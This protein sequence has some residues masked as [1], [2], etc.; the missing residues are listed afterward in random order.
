[1]EQNNIARNL[2]A[3][4][5]LNHLEIC[6][7]NAIIYLVGLAVVIVTVLSLFGLA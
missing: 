5:A 2:G 4:G 1:V 3:R 7:M 6:S